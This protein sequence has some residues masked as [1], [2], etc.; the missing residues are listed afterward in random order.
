MKKKYRAVILILASNNNQIYKNC[1]KIWKQYMNVDTS[2]KV[3]FVYG[4]IPPNNILECY[5]PDSDIIFE[6]IEESY[7]V[8]IQKTIEA[9]K[10]IKTKIEFDFLIRTNLTTFWDF[11]K[12]HLHLHDLPT[13]NCYSGDGP[14]PNYNAQGYYLSGTD[15]IVTPEMISS[16]IL[17]EHKVDFQIVEDAA[18]GKY[19]HG[20]FGAPMLP[21]RICFFEDIYSIQEYDKII[22]R[23]N[24]AKQNN[25]DHYRV[26][27]A[28]ENREIIDYFIYQCLLKNI[29]NIEI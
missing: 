19:F 15:T 13:T 17:N 11:N 14:L 20:V 6:N 26:K 12:L 23:I 2:I 8:L 16:I 7:P 28:S 10:I 4:K 24:N 1:R 21:N 18:M 3:F 27:S 25:K 9:F 5:D 22:N 29:Y